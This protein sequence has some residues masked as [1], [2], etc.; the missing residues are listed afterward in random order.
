M[1]VIYFRQ[2]YK[3]HHY[4]FTSLSPIFQAYMVFNPRVVKWIPFCLR[5]FLFLTCNL[6][7][8]HKVDVIISE[9]VA[10]AAM[11]LFVKWSL[12]VALRNCV[13]VQKVPLT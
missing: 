8:N 5:S 7:S 4:R 9:P 1:T 11:R 3:L 13:R 2:A 6:A 12:S 10:A